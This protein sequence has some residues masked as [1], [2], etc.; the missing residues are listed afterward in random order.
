VEERR[1]N[2]VQG[3]ENHDHSDEYPDQVH[4]RL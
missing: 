1:E 2:V 3:R 4:D